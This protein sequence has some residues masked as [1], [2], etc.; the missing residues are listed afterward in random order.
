MNSASKIRA[1]ALDLEIFSITQ[2]MR[3]TTLIPSIIRTE[4]QRMEQEGFLTSEPMRAGGL[5]LRY[6]L[7]D[8]LEKRL[9]LVR[10][11]EQGETA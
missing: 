1:I 9:A 5:L 4:L 7:T 10:S 8:D 3:A 2:V 6:R 11:I